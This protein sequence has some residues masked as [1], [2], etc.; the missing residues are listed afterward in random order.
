MNNFHLCD[1]GSVGP[2]LRC[3]V[4]PVIH[5]DEDILHI[6]PYILISW[7]WW[8]IIWSM[9]KT[10]AQLVFR[11]CWRRDRGTRNVALWNQT[12]ALESALAVHPVKMSFHVLFFILVSHLGI[13]ETGSEWVWDVGEIGVLCPILNRVVEQRCCVVHLLCIPPR[14]YDED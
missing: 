3:E 10:S 11:W 14:Y 7:W 1:I 12:P 4:S 6:P 13:I 9:T 2:K 8:W 5:P